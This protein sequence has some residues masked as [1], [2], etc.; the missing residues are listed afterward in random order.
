M[1]ALRNE[2]TDELDATIGLRGKLMI[3]RWLVQLGLLLY[4]CAIAMGQSLSSLSGVVSDPAGAVI[5]GATLVLVD[6]ASN[7]TR[8]AT[9]S[10]DG[11]FQFPQATPGLYTLRAKKDG[12]NDVVV[13]NIRLLVNTPATLNISFEKISGTTQ[14]VEVSAEAIQLNTVDA[15]LGNSFGTKPIIQLPLEGRKVDRLLSLQSGISYLGDADPVNGG[16]S[17]ATD[18]NGAV[19]GARSDQS[20]ISLD[21][22]DNNNQQTRAPFNGSLRVTSDSVQ[23]FRVTTTNANADS[24]RGSGAQITMVTRSGTN[25][26]HGA[27]YWYLRNKALNAN[28]FFGN[29]AGLKTPKLNRH[30]PGARIGGPIKKD[31]LFYFFNY[32]R[33]WD[34]LESQV[35]RTVAREHL[36]AGNV[37]YVSAAG[38]VVTVTPERLLTLLPDARSINSAALNA[39]RTTPLPNNTLVGDGINTAGFLFNAP[40]K[41]TYDTYVGKVDFNMNDKNR[42]FFR[43]QL[44]RDDEGGTPQFPGLA[45]NVVTQDRSRGFAVGW[46]STLSTTFFSSTRFGQT[47]QFVKDAGIAD[48][49]LITFRGMSDIVGATTSFQRTSPTWN[50]TQDFTKIAGNHTFQFGGSLRVYTN[51]RI[52]FASSFFSGNINSSWMTNSGQILSAP[53]A[54]TTLP[55]DQRISAGSRTSFNDGVAAVLGLVT[56]VTSRY[57]YLPRPDGSVVAQAQG[58]GVPRVFQGEEAEMYFQDSWKIRRNLT[59]TGGVRYMYWPAIYEKNGVQTSTNIPLSEWFDRRVANADNGL[60]GQTGLDPIS[61]QLANRPGG[62]PLYSNLHNWSPRL[63]LVYS[64]TN[65]WV[66]RSGWGMYYDVFGA[67]LIRLGDASALGLS[68]SLNNAS[69][70]LS[71]AEAPRFTGLTSLPQALVTPA[72][73]AQFPVVQP[74]NFAITNSIDDRLKAPYVMRWNLSVTR[75]L[76]NGLT[77]TAAYVA[78]EGRRTLTSEDLATPLNVRDPQSRQTYYEAAQALTRLIQANTAV[79]AVRPLPFF[80]NMFP[81]WATGG[82]TATQTAYNLFSDFYPDATAAVEN[83]DRFSDPTPSRLGAFAFYSRQYSYLRALRSV[84]K[85]S[86]HSLQ[87]NIRKQWRNGDSLDFN[88]TWS[89]ALDM[90]STTENNSNETRGIIISP[91]NRRQMWASSD[92]DQR[93]NWNLAGFYGLPFGKGK[94][95]GGNA[96]GLLN[97]VIG[98]WQLGTIYRQSTGLPVSVGHNRTWPTNYNI[99]GWATTTGVFVDGTN[100]NAPPSVTGGQSGPNIFQNPAEALKSFGFTLPGE[101]GNRNNI[102]G[103]GLFNIDMNLNKSFNMPWE[104]H[105]AQFRWEVFNVT[106]SVRFDPQNINLSL[107]NPGA[108][109]RYGGTLMPSR[110][111]QMA[112]RYDF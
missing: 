74:N 104:G 110:V 41:R 19:N 16:V 67:G 17:T 81:Q 21:G 44:Q 31:K 22:I 51:D 54:A 49:P 77:V 35:N 38:N 7:A 68:T 12:F 20:N 8:E 107:G 80:E 29:A 90:G 106:N 96:T 3:N 97:G 69:G 108:F 111:M 103:D 62:R 14:T 6:K 63:S 87:W 75:E 23:E 60:A 71:L 13:Q 78:S 46:D 85:S 58:E 99:T 95:F 40:V 34:S 79:G 36:R 94:K 47:R 57:N 105:S 32:E 26:L 100:K 88:Y 4:V 33:Q 30:I 83:F 45:P 18:R 15:T 2:L 76:G 89:H 39:L 70:R 9:S 52:N 73:P 37:N 11:S 56:Q 5:P 91:Y 61:Y 101:V 66:I 42:F 82:L 65:K 59:L 93:Q 98:G 92:F 50:G 43:Y 1:P 112:I 48:Y 55:A 10:S 102:R 64:P 25:D 72:P 109:G 53:L 27:A 28:T 24:S 86:Y 84:G